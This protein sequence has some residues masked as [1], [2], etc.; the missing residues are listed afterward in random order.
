[1][2]RCRIAVTHTQTTGLQ[3]YPEYLTTMS[4]NY[5]SFHL[6]KM[7]HN[8][9]NVDLEALAKDPK[10]MISYYIIIMYSIK[11]IDQIHLY[12]ILSRVPE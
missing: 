11:M 4:L 8:K 9:I 10:K 1:V 3:S 2:C 5:D 7:Y 6:S 12:S